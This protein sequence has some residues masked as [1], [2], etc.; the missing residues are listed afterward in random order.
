MENVPPPNN[1]PNVPEEEPIL[2]Q[3]S[4]ALI[5]FAPQGIGVQIP[6]NNN[7]WLEEDPDED[8][9][10]D[11]KEE[12]KE[13]EIKDDNMVNDEDDEGNEEDDAEVINPYEEANPHNRP[14]PTSDEEIWKG[15][16][17]LSKQMHD[18]YR[19][20]K[21]MARKLRQDELC[22]NGQEFDIAALDSTE[23]SIYTAPVP[24]ADDP[25]V[26]MRYATMD[27]QG[28]EDV[29]TDTPWDTQPFEPCGSPHGIEAAIKDERERVRMEA[30]RA[31]GPARGPAATPMAR[32]CSFTGFIKC[33]PMQFYGTE[34]AVGLVRWFEKIENSFEISECVEGKTVKFTTATLH[35]QALTWWNSQVATLGRDVANGRPWTEVKQMMTDEFCLTEEFQRLEDELRHLKLRDMNIAAYTERFNELALLCPDDVPN[36]KKKVEFYIKGLPEIIKGE[37]T[38]SR[39]ATLNEAVRMAHALMEQK[40]QAKNERI[41]KGIKRKWE[42]NNNNNSHNR[43]ATVQSNVV[44]YECEER[45]HK[46]RACPKKFDRQGR[47]VQGQAY[48][49]RDNEHN[50]GLNVVTGTFLLNNRYATMSFD[51]GVDKSFVNINLSHLIDIKPVKLNSSYEVELAD[52]KVV[53]TNSVLRGCTLNLLDHLFDV[54]LMPIELA[55]KYI[56]RGSQLFIAQVTEKEPAKKQLQDVLMI[57]NFP[58]VFPDDLIGLPPPRQVEFR[59]ELIPNATPV[60][61][62][63][64][65]LAPTELK[66]LSDQLKELL[67]KGFIRPSSSP[68]GAPVLFV[69]K[70]DG[71]F[72]ICIDYQE[73]NKLTVKNRYPL[74]MI[75]N[76]FDQLQGL[77]VYSKIDLRYGHFK[78]Q[79][80]LFGL[81]NVLA[82]FMDL[83]NRVWKPYLDK[84]VIVFIDDILIYSKN[85]EDHEKHL[86]IILELLKNEEF[87]AKFSKCDFRLESVQFL[88][89]VIDNKGVH[90]DPAKKNKKYEW[91]MEQDKAFQTLKQKLCSAPILALPKGTENFVVYCDA[92]LKGF[93]AVLMQREKVT[94]YASRQLKKHE[95]NYTTHDLE[96]GAIMFALRLWRH[97][98]YGTKCIMYTDHE[99]LQYILDQ[100]ELNLRQRH[101]IELLSDY[102]CE[103]RYHPGK[104][105]VVADAL[106]QKEKEPLR[107][108][109]L[110]MTVH[111]NLPERILNAWIEAMKRDNVNAKNLRRLIKQIFEIRSNGIRCFK[112]RIWLPL[113]GGIRDLVMHESHKSKYSI[114]PR[115]GKMHQDLKKLYWWPNMKADIATFVSKSLTYA[116]EKKT[117]DFVSGLPRTP[118][119]YDSIWVIVDRLTKSAHFLPMK[120]TDNIEKLAQLYLKEIVCRHEVPVLIISDKDSLFTSR[121]WE[122]LQKA[123]GTQLNLS[124]A[125]HPET[126]GQSERMIQT[127]EDMLRACVIDFGSNWD[128]HLP[129]VEFSYNNSYHASIKVAPFEALYGQKCR[130]PVCWSE[131]KD[132]Q[133]TSPEL[134][135][136]T[137]KKIVQIKNR[138][139]TAR[140][141]QKSYAD[142]RRKSMEFEVGDMVMLKVSPWKGVI[143]FEKHGKLSPRYVGPF[144]IIE[145]IGPVAYKLELPDKLCGIHNTFHVSNVKKCMADENLV[146]PLEEIQLDDKL[147]F[148]KEPVEI[149]D[150]EVN[151]L[152]QS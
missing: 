48:V 96:L 37:T 80:V 67:E 139:L 36:E 88:S 101:W 6:N 22:M 74:S 11:P 47:N 64:Y 86:K 109:S 2:N 1:N 106:S 59:I 108:R 152:K 27:T 21:K 8:E 136:E 83:M 92:S 113:F 38:S 13:E 44:C 53:S 28:D 119:G 98:L 104:G 111:T 117:M 145:R 77:S 62:A 79:V 23:P 129:L 51:S 128:R 118:S 66:E 95:E 69:K 20:E 151:Q 123:L 143:R 142:V 84:F 133:L 32:E 91:G 18:R 7:G 112:E 127:L 31:G 138:L 81:T 125:Y 137:T 41:A 147:H 87:Y 75:D 110:V 140:S 9:E 122:T 134:I 60:T 100:K 148:I 3:A 26:M 132:S 39:P 89:H 70:K 19:T 105:N 30:T 121:F 99:S 40:I 146:I 103:I 97:Y 14:P 93:G 5:E 43:G 71:S 12:P 57:C 135:R 116:K 55:R 115:S 130:S 68:W 42:N 25:Y 90:V 35:G 58:K 16:M 149:M 24:C 82:V 50:Q 124:T 144:K 107:V 17:K 49:I 45:G 85:N 33:G 46:S 150:R 131:V 114:H 54:D 29:D 141:H 15:V 76:L 120:K 10:E 94:A 63:P 102:D 72:Q 56:E 78:F 4:A 52:G 61:Y 126:D 65:R 73:L 34:G